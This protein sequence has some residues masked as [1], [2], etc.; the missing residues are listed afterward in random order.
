VA[1]WLTSVPDPLISII[2]PIRDAAATVDAALASIQRQTEA[3]FECIVVD[4]GSR[5]DS[6]AR[7]RSLANRDPRFHLVATP[8]R[9]IVEAL[10]LGLTRCRAP[11]VA[12]M[13]GDDLMFRRRLAVQL[14]ALEGDVELAGVGCHVRLFPRRPLTQGRLAYERWLNSLH[15]AE[16]VAR[17]AYVECP[18]A[19]PTFFLRRD[20]LL[21]HGYA[22]RGWPEDYDLVLRL[23][24]AGERL[25]VVAEPL[26]LWRDGP[27][28]LSR[29]G[30]AYRLER[31]TACKAYHLARNFLAE[32][33]SYVLWGYGD[34]GRSLARALAAEHK[35][36]THIVE[37]HPGRLGQRIFGAAVVPPAAL[38]PL[39]A[40]HPRQRVVVSVAGSEARAL[41]RA[42]LA[43][44][45]FRD[46]SDFV[47]AA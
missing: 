16:D 10:T 34:T 29:T 41:I 32:R 31:F 20:V 1:N 13:D 5:D 26:L 38:G 17:D 3:R 9:G 30:D 23:L 19:H 33:S 11:Y 12:R 21:R 18:L 37:L 8:P 6:A 7:V 46:G 42:E 39:R 2:V 40:Q 15:G 45:G 24:G 22:D 43:R 27:A 36:P 47:C 25:G 44:L 14:A 4:D 35:H 28:R